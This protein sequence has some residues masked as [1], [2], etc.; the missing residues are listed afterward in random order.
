MKHRIMCWASE[1]KIGRRT[2]ITELGREFELAHQSTLFISIGKD[3]RITTST[4]SRPGPEIWV[5]RFKTL[6]PGLLRN[7]LVE[8]NR[9]QAYLTLD[10][11]P[12]EAVLKPLLALCGEAFDWVFILAP[13]ESSAESVAALDASDLLLWITKPSIHAAQAHQRLLEQLSRLHFPHVFCQIIANRC[14]DPAPLSVLHTVP[15]DPGVGLR[16]RE[17]LR[18]LADILRTRATLYRVKQVPQEKSVQDL[19]VNQLKT[20]IQPEL[21]RVLETQKKQSPHEALGEAKVAKET[22]EAFLAADRAAGGSRQERTEIV[23]RVLE[24]VLG[25][26]PL[27]PLLKDP[28]ISE[29]MVNGHGCVFVEKKGRLHATDVQ[30]ASESQLRIVVDRI[31]APIGRRVDESMPLCDAR[32]ADGS[33]VNIVL[34]PLA[35][36]GPTV[37]IRK[38]S[39]KKWSLDDLTLLGSLNPEMQ[40]FL[41]T[42]V[43][44]RRNMVVAGGTG[45]GKTTL[46]NALSSAIPEDERI[47]TIE[48]AAELRLQKPHVVRLEARPP[49][50]ENQGE[51]SIRRLVM[52]ALRMRPDRIIVG[53]CRGGEAL[54]ML[55]AMNTGHDGSLTTV[56]ANSP[57]DALGR[58]ET[59]VLMAGMDLPVRVIREQIRSAV[60]VLV[61]QSR[62]ADGSRRVTSITEITGME[63]DTLSTQEL[64][65]WRQGQF[66]TT[67][68]ASIRRPS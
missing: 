48:D 40:A 27:E 26:G 41:Q 45:S 4:I 16:R 42:S 63:G 25:L 9:L 61:Q 35:I 6:S 55:Q 52:N 64:F 19:L 38:F 30:F 47:V 33:R 43:I 62:L 68:L 21:L 17:S 3:A 66:V 37:T 22:V 23:T 18:L 24:E 51:I 59:L 28:D 67:G 1:P 39:A 44:Q 32:L 5:P 13:Q 54:D 10:A 49:N 65:C 57:R 31:V 2:L 34:P 58:L 15:D 60:H 14:V 29:V 50:A 7:Y 8:T 12:T 11:W 20:Q 36:D 56:H 53:E 46:L